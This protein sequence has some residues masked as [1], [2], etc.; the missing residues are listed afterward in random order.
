[1]DPSASCVCIIKAFL[2][3]STVC[4]TVL[5]C[6][7]C[8]REEACE[9][10][11]PEDPGRGRR[12]GWRLQKPQLSSQL[13]RLR[14]SAGG[15]A[16]ILLI[17]SSLL[18]YLHFAFACFL[19]SSNTPPP[20]LQTTRQRSWWKPCR[21]WRMLHQVTRLFVR[22]SRPCRRKFRMFLCWRRSLVGPERSSS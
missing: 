13:G 8:R 10:K 11:L 7:L 22:R 6:G 17:W 3:Y 19:P 16:S 21:T 1:M 4:Q 18:L 5:L 20:P 14:S 2:F 12:R 9:T 15:A